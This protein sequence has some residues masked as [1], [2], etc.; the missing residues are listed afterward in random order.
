MVKHGDAEQLAT[1]FEAPRQGA[2]FWARSRIS[3]RMVVGQDDGARVHEDQ[4]LEDFA[5]VD[6]AH[7]G[8]SDADSVDADD[9]MLRVKSY[10]HEMLAIEPLEERS[11]KPVRFL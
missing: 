5:G 7:G 10:D 6:D 4:W 2:V 8:R 1:V 3:A 11:E 9:G